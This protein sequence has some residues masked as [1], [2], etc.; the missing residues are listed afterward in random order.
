MFFRGIKAVVFQGTIE[1]REMQLDIFNRGDREKLQAEFDDSQNYRDFVYQTLD[2]FK[3]NL[4]VQALEDRASQ[5]YRQLGREL[6]YKHIE[7]QQYRDLR[8]LAREI[9]DIY[10]ELKNTDKGF[11]IPEHI[12]FDFDEIE[13]ITGTANQPTGREILDNPSMNL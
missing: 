7:G 4:D 8:S 10:N 5:I 12:K 2:N 6:R 3:K 13:K 9:R 11:K 1:F